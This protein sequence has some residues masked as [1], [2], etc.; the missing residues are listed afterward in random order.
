MVL[1]ADVCPSQ[2]EA[3]HLEVVEDFANHNHH[4]VLL[5]EASVVIDEV[6][7]RNGLRSVDVDAFK[8]NEVV[9]IVWKN[10]RQATV[11]LHYPML[12]QA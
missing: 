12:N 7:H 9:P 2:K 3:K 4:L 8:Q 11:F 5:A 10:V 6:P 1:V